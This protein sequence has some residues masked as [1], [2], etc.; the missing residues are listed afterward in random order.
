MTEP[1]T[2]IDGRGLWV[3]CPKCGNDRRF[4]RKQCRRITDTLRKRHLV[5]GECGQRITYYD[6]KAE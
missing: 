4:R 3:V 5:C 1:Y 2:E 6:Q